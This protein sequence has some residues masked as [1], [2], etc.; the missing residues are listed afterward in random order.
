[1]NHIQKM[2]KLKYLIKKHEENIEYSQD[3]IIEYAGEIKYWE[4]KLENDT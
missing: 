2:S 3:K 4:W 1:M